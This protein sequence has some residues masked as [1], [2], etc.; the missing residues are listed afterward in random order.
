MSDEKTMREV[1]IALEGQASVTFWSAD[2][3][4]CLH[5]VEDGLRKYYRRWWRWRRS[6]TFVID[7]PDCVVVVPIEKVLAIK[8]GSSQK[9]ANPPK[10]R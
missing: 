8:L 4:G 6:F 10:S 5:H 9:P 3:I 7:G 1:T 2:P